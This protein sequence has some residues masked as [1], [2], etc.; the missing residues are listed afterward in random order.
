MSPPK[1]EIRPPVTIRIE[2]GWSN[3][4]ELMDRVR[5]TETRLKR[6][7]W[8]ISID[9]KFLAAHYCFR[10]KDGRVAVLI[11]NGGNESV[12]IENRGREER[13]GI[14]EGGRKIRVKWG[15]TTGERTYNFYRFGDSAFSPTMSEVI[16]LEAIYIRRD[17][18]SGIPEG[19]L[20]DIL[21]AAKKVTNQA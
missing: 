12:E 19:Y 7:V 18:L 1:S 11:D 21:E 5:E 2:P 14:F 20:R 15:G 3:L 6:P 8:A 4:G 16:N 10:Q 17:D 13:I 9:E